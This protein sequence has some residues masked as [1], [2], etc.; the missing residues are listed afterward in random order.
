MQLPPFADFLSLEIDGLKCT[1]HVCDEKIVQ[2]IVMKCF[3][4][5]D[6]AVQFVLIYHSTYFLDILFLPPHY[7]QNCPIL[8]GAVGRVMISGSGC[9]NFEPCPKYLVFPVNVAAFMQLKSI[10][11]LTSEP[12]S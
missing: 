4:G 6:C 1:V 7:C 2:N 8:G 10:Q 5:Q 11:R 9:G 3:T 12:D